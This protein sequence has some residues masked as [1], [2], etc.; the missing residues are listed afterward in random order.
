MAGQQRVV[1]HVGVGEDVLGV[2]AGPLALVA[3]AVAVVGGDP[4]V[5]AERGEPGELVLG[6]RLG[7]REVERGGAALAARPARGQRRGQRRQLVG[8]RLARGGAGGEDDV[9]PGVRRV[10]R[11]GLV[12]PGLDHP[13]GAVGRDHRRVG[14]VRPRRGAGRSGGQPLEVGQPALATGDGGQPVDHLGHAAWR[15]GG[16]HAASMTN[17]AD[18]L[19]TCS[20]G[21][22]PTPPGEARAAVFCRRPRRPEPDPSGSRRLLCD[23]CTS[24]GSAWFHCAGRVPGARMSRVLAARIPG[25]WTWT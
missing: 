4:D 23:L 13:A 8:E 6:Q 24:L 11:H 3:A 2:V 15:G 12:P 25:E 21:G 5:E 16:G 10:G 17:A 9:L 7:R 18:V 20:Y 22:A 1:Q 14:P 19:A